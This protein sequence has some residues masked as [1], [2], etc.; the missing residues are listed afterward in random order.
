MRVKEEEIKDGNDFQGGKLQFWKRHTQC[1]MQLHSSP[2]ES[3]RLLVINHKK[4]LCLYSA[5]ENYVDTNRHI[6]S[7]TMEELKST[8]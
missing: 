6:C 5:L 3:I 1:G 4:G 8:T 7:F 2:P